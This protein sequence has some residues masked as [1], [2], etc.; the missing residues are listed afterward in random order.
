MAFTDNFTEASDTNLEDHTPSGGTAWTLTGTAGAALVFATT[1]DLRSRTTSASIYVCDDQGSADHYVQARLKALSTNFPNS[2]VAC[3]LL[4]ASNFVGWRCFGTGSAGLRLT[5]VVAGTPADLFTFQ[6]VD[7]SVYR[8]EVTGSDVTIWEDGVQK[9][10]T[11]TYNGSTSETSQGVRIGSD[12][13]INWIDDFEADVLGGGPTERSATDGMF[14]TEATVKNREMVVPDAH[15]FGDTRA[16]AIDRV[17]V[18]TLLLPTLLSKVMDMLHNDPLLLVDVLA[19]E[20]TGAGEIVLRAAMDGLLLGDVTLRDLAAMYGDSLFLVDSASTEVTA[21]QEIVLRAATD[22]LMLGELLAKAIEKSFMDGTFLSDSSLIEKVSAG[23]DILLTEGVLLG[24]SFAIDRELV[25]VGLSDSVFLSDVVFLN[26]LKEFR[27]TLQVNDVVLKEFGLASVSNLILDELLYKALDIVSR[28][29]VLLKDSAQA[30]WSGAVA[31]FLV[32]ARLGADD[33]LGVG[34][35]VSSPCNGFD[36][37]EIITGDS[38]T[39]TGDSILV[40]GDGALVSSRGCAGFGFGDFAGINV[41]QSD[42][43][44]IDVSHNLW[45]IEE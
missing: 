35:S 44:G 10:T 25:S 16:L 3:R 43:P 11:Y 45:R 4:D 28:N 17:L 30:E 33:V 41:T 5:E 13:A 29:N 22:G 18:D 32:Y 15:M 9:G 6:G 21:A 24:D 26:L 38:D 42:Y 40:T 14:L 27:D 7:E 36:V 19:L 2:Y 34:Y 39:I 23:L 1:D 31:D 20:Q 8:V 37:I 12:I